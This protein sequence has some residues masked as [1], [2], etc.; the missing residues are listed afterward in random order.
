MCHTAYL[1]WSAIL[2]ECRKL[3]AFSEL[4]IPVLFVIS[5]GTVNYEILP[6][7]YTFATSSISN[8]PH[9]NIIAVGDFDCKPETIDTVDNIIRLNPELVIALGDFSYEDTAD[10]WLDIVDPIDEKMK[11]VIGN[12]EA[13]SSLEQYLE[14]FNLTEQYYSFNY[15]NVH[16]LMLSDYV[17]YEFGSEQYD[18]VNND[19]QDAATDPNIDWIIVSHHTHP[20]A[21]TSSSVVPSIPSWARLYH[22]LFEKYGVDIVL[23]GHQH[24]YQRTYPLEYNSDTP[25]EPI[26]SD[27]NGRKYYIDPDGQIFATVGTGGATL[28][29]PEGKS[30][31]TDT[32][33]VGWGLLNIAIINED[34]PKVRQQTEQGQITQLIATFYANEGQEKIDEF[35]IEKLKARP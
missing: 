15:Q 22:P 17:S 23:Q 2:T 4:L 31:Y 25:E 34:V 32:Q 3:P 11:I 29:Y 6:F 1:L 33:Y 21:S 9:F 30:F 35:T 16:F 26:I 10:C 19:L 12:H 24:N 8:L 28:H 27:N 5:I 7:G 18:F 14:H 20:Y 13:E